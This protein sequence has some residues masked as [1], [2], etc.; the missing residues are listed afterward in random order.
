MDMS[1]VRDALSRAAVRTQQRSDGPPRTTREQLVDWARAHLRDRE[2]VVVS[3]REPYSHQHGPDGIRAIRNAGGLT[4]ALDAVTQAL[5]GLWV[6]HGSGSADRETV[7]EADRVACPPER[8]R[9]SLRRIWLSP[10]DQELYYSRFSNGALWPLCHIAYVRPRFRTADFE[11]Y[12]EVNRRF[13]EAV[14]SE[15]GSR[16]ALIFIQDY[17]LA[18]AAQFLKERRPDLQVALFWH[19]PWPN[20][21]VFRILPWRR[22]ILEGMLANDLVGF[23]VRGHALNFLDSVAA[24]L[25]A[26]VDREH[27]AVERQGKRTWVRHFPISVNADEIA[28]MAESGEA[29]ATEQ[30]LRDELGLQGCKVGLGVDRMDYTKGIPE[31]LEALERMLEKHPEWADQL[32]FIQIGVPSRVELKEYRDIQRRMRRVAQRINQRFP[33]SGGP[34]VHV[35]E[36]NLDFG[37]LVPYYRMADLCAVTSLHDGMNMVAKEYLAASPDLEG[38]LVLSPFTGAARELERAWLASPYDRDGLADAYHAAL[39]ESPES[40]R[41]RMAALRETVLRHNI[42]D[43]AIEVF[44]TALGLNLIT[45]AAESTAASGS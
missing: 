5:G 24:T 35:I 17:H 42:F 31:R 16:P 34:T 8:P 4:V 36:A 27:L 7:D 22:E 25:E 32:C 29:R 37:D 14:L 18:L 21:E 40:R 43:W 39:V 9:Y 30:R 13:A 23:H 41:D 10:S 28:A 2:L 19:I 20:T 26:R 15:V 12:R 44:D 11:R 3:N 33:R 1:R 6:A 38:A 45:P